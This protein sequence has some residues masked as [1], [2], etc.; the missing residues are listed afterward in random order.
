MGRTL[1][2]VVAISIG[3]ASEASTGCSASPVEPG[4]FRD[5]DPSARAG[6]SLTFLSIAPPSMSTIDSRQSP[7]LI[8][9]ELEYDQP[10][11]TPSSRAWVCLAR[12]GSS[13]LYSS[14]RKSPLLAQKGRAEGHAGMYYVNG[15]PAFPETRYIV[16]FLVSGELVA[17]RRLYE[18]EIGFDRLSSEVFASLRVEHVL[19]WR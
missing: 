7:A 6:Y 11:V 18:D 9:V 13:F 5:F 14:C 4:Q 2:L 16:A 10:S 12:D 15:I 8:K 19:Y 1:S 17:G 3:C